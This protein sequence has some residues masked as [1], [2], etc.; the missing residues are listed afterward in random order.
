MSMHTP[1]R[2]LFASN[3]KFH[4]QRLGVSQVT[5]SRAAGLG[6]HTVTNIENRT[7]NVRLDTV[8]RLAIALNVDPCLLLSSN[9]MEAPGD[10]VERPL[11]DSVAQNL[12]RLRLRLSLTQEQAATSAG[13]GRIYAYKIESKTVAATLDTLD[14]LARVVGVETCNCWFD[15]G[16]KTRRRAN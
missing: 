7:A 9:P 16:K 14:A 3:L 15:T 4:R 10:Y 1:A 11:G 2:R 6:V 8:N 13:L 5:L 12:K